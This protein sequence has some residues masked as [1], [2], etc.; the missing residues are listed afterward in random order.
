MVRDHVFS[1][2]VKP[3]Y[4]KPSD[5]SLFIGS[6]RIVLR[7]F[8]AAVYE[9]L[10][11]RKPQAI[12]LKAPTGSGKTYVLLLFMF[13]GVYD[14]V[15][16]IY[17]TRV[18]AKDQYDTIFNVLESM[19]ERVNVEEVLGVSEEEADR[20]LKEAEEEE[21]REG[22]YVRYPRLREFFTVWDVD[23]INPEGEK[24]KHKVLLM[25]VTSE[26]VET[27]RVILN[28][29][30]KREVLSE[31][32]T[33]LFPRVTFRM[34]FTVPEYPYIFSELSYGEFEA[35]GEKLLRILRYFKDFLKVLA[36]GHPLDGYIEELRRSVRRY[37]PLEVSR[38]SLREIAD[39]YAEFFRYPVFIDEFHLYT[40]LSE[41]SLLTLLYFYACNP[42]ATRKIV[43]SSA[44]HR[45]KLLK[46]SRVILELLGFEVI[47]VDTECGDEGPKEHLIRGRTKVFF[48][49]V[50]TRPG[51]VGLLEAQRYVPEVAA[52]IVREDWSRKT[53]VI[54]DRVKLVIDTCKRIHEELS[55]IGKDR[56]VRKCYVTSVRVPAEYC[57][58]PALSS[59]KRGKY[60]ILVGN[61]AIAQGLDLKYVERGV[62]YAKDIEAFIQ[63][64]GR[65]SRGR[66][67][68][69]HV[70][71]DSGKYKLK[72]ELK[73][74]ELS[75][76]EL[77][78]LLAERKAFPEPADMSW[79]GEPV[80]F[81]KLVFPVFA[82]ILLNAILRRDAETTA[83]SEL[84]A[85]LPVLAEFISKYLD[86]VKPGGELKEYL[87][88]V[89]E[90]LEGLNVGPSSFYQLTSFRSVSPINAEVESC[91]R[92]YEGEYSLV[93]LARNFE[94]VEG[95]KKP[96]RALFDSRM[97]ATPAIVVTHKRVGKRELKK[98]GENLG[99]LTGKVLSF[100]TLGEI[101]SRYGA[102][103]EQLDREGSRIGG[104]VK[105]SRIL[106][107]AS[108]EFL[109]TPVLLKVPA[110]PTE[111]F[112]DYAWYM[113]SVENALL[114]AI[115]EDGLK[116]V[117]LAVLL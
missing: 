38:G 14:G 8:Q 46:L 17:P 107:K 60:D 102:L 32:K 56:E 6:R 52:S 97:H 49:C 84:R 40:G 2:T 31:L 74:R 106:P 48:H 73:D 58:P 12:F 33:K 26:T 5:K 89:L 15:V 75:Y 54:L 85:S 104:I 77:I 13:V 98:L 18:L 21:L 10:S 91:G 1:F 34:I 22:H 62:I 81:F 25:L 45:E 114:I 78:E 94:V 101:L 113:A 115:R 93:V 90:F 76:N 67:G 29:E 47:E 51:F 100:R 96:L 116:V 20:R 109:S 99:R 42:R 43:F 36:S 57:E 95:R 110:R 63:R 64:F 105:L 39:I 72:E 41:I 79:L 9:R 23:A 88:S 86:A 24:V 83:Y 30:S 3:L 59:L 112:E 16:G 92:T 69:V 19:A 50:D 82:S 66:E 27:L 53:M 87:S 71:V 117:G 37:M 103:L 70:V 111:D 68:E 108:E 55:L 80:G 11:D 61:L 7:D 65:I 4:A 28:K 35:E 44:T